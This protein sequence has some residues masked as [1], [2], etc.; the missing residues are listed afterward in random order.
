MSKT[1]KTDAHIKEV[2]AMGLYCDMNVV[3]PE[4][5]REQ[6]LEIARLNLK[7]GN[8]T[9]E[10]NLNGSA[11]AQIK[12]WKD[13]GD[14]DQDLRRELELK[15]EKLLAGNK[16]LDSAYWDERGRR[17][18]ISEAYVILERENEELKK[19][20]QALRAALERRHAEQSYPMPDYVRD[21]LTKAKANQKI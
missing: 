3:T 21:A 12:W 17:Q 19:E 16:A 14:D 10:A 13:T 15:Y 1:P 18:R 4:F 2:E 6:E 5:A 9:D 8:P 7:L 11:Y 20:N